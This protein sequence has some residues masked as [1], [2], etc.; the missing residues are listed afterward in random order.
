MSLAHA[1]SFGNN[2]SSNINNNGL[3]HQNLS[4]YTTHTWTTT[5]VQR[6]YNTAVYAPATMNMLQTPPFHSNSHEKESGI[7]VYIWRL[8]MEF[9]HEFV[10]R[11]GLVITCGKESGIY[12]C[13]EALWICWDP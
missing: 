3:L 7:C 2:G 8:K 10:L 4:P 6:P 12:M 9:L 11:S 5:Y 1:T 13:V